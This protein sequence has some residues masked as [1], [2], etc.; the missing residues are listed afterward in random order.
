MS[1]IHNWTRST[2]YSSSLIVF[3]H[4]ISIK[5][6]QI[7]I[8]FTKCRIKIHRNQRWWRRLKFPVILFLIG[9]SKLSKVGVHCS[10]PLRICIFVS[11]SQ[12]T[13]SINCWPPTSTL[14]A[15]YQT[16]MN[17]GRSTFRRNCCVMPFNGITLPLGMS[18][19]T[20][21]MNPW[22]N[23]FIIPISAP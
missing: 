5:I 12:T 4:L 3:I 7:I 17:H 16:Q 22:H 14:P 18:V 15:T 21:C 20:V 9:H 2:T 11:S 19:K 1:Q 8:H 23:I 13:L 10:T 6:I